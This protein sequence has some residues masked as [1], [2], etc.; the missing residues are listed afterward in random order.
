MGEEDEEEEEEEDEAEDFDEDHRSKISKVED[1]RQSKNGGFV[2]EE[3]VDYEECDLAQGIQGWEHRFMNDAG[4]EGDDK[5]EEADADAALRMALAFTFGEV[6][7]D[8]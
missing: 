1:G 8:E 5:E 6:N 7:V 4:A 3:S 2:A